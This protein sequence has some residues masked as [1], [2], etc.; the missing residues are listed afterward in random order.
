MFRRCGRCKRVIW[1]AKLGL[2]LWVKDQEAFPEG[3][4][5]RCYSRV[6]KEWSNNGFA[7][8]SADDQPS[9]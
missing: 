4:H 3:V 7:H 8:V 6:L 1:F 2:P 5:Y 9:A